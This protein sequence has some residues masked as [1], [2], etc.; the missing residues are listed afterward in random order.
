MLVLNTL[1]DMVQ[2]PV[3]LGGNPWSLEAGLEQET[4]V[5]VRMYSLLW[6]CELFPV[7]SGLCLFRVHLAV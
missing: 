6:S 1:S 5:V 4:G 3:S 2:G 7:L